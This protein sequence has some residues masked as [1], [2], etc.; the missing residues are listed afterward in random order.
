M[1]GIPRQ[2]AELIGAACATADAVTKAHA[3][4]RLFDVDINRNRDLIFFRGDMI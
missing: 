4:Q 1:N 3:F 2:A